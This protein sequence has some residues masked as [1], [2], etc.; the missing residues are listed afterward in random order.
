MR[1]WRIAYVR[2]RMLSE[3][4]FFLK[5]EFSRKPNFPKFP[6]CGFNTRHYNRE[7]TLI[8]FFESRICSEF[9]RIFCS[10]IYR[11]FRNV[12]RNVN[13]TH[14]SELNTRHDNREVNREVTLTHLTRAWHERKLCALTNAPPVQST[15]MGQNYQRYSI[16]TVLPLRFMSCTLGNSYSL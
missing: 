15:Q 3:G 14:D 7:A 5:A 2:Q 12:N 9:V 13:W 16:L 1:Q 6:N 11:M 10:N 4:R 8:E